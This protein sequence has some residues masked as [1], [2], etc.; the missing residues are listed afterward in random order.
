[1]AA[2]MALLDS[3]RISGLVL[4]DAVGIDVPG[5]PVVDFFSLTLPE[6]AQYSYHEPDKFRIDPSTLSTDQQA[7]MA[8]NRASLATYAGTA[9]TDPGLA[10]RL[11][12]VTA[13]TLVLWGESDRVVDVDFGRAFAAAIPSARLRLLPQTGHLPQIETP[14]PMLNALW[15]FITVGATSS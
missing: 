1:M 15:G 12:G 5:H 4:V 3:P 8:G 2:E 6:V 13:P 7:A 10:A 11:A 9:M 14:E